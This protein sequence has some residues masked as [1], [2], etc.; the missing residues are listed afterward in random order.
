MRRS[1]AIALSMPLLLGCAAAVVDGEVA[2]GTA[3][4]VELARHAL[5]RN[6]EGLIRSRFGLRDVRCRADGG[7]LVVFEQANLVRRSH[8][9]AMQ[10]PGA[11]PENWAGGY[12]V[13]DVDTDS[14]VLYFFSESPEVACPV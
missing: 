3:E 2:P 12:G 1:V 14:E 10:G 13:D 7:L 4:A 9:F 5:I 11:D 6:E 8:A